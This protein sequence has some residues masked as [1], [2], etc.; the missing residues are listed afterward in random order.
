MDDIEHGNGLGSGIDVFARRDRRK[1]VY[2][3]IEEERCPFPHELLLRG[4]G[5][6][7]ADRKLGVSLSVDTHLG[8]QSILDPPVAQNAHR[9]LRFRHCELVRE[10]LTVDLHSRGHRARARFIVLIGNDIFDDQARLGRGHDAVSEEGSLIVR[11]ARI[12]H[13]SCGAGITCRQQ[14]QILAHLGLGR[15]R[16]I[17]DLDRDHASD[18]QHEEDTDDDPDHSDAFLTRCG[19][20]RESHPS[21]ATS[22]RVRPRGTRLRNRNRRVHRFVLLSAHH[23]RLTPIDNP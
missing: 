4:I 1:R 16:T 5:A 9:G 21:I 7:V 2:A 23:V 8:H 14:I 6:H 20:R 11:N 3:R 10:T 17:G 19:H 18:H 12:D 13:R 15:P 22:R